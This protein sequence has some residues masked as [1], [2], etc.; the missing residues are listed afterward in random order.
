M[1][2]GKS[3]SES[4][5]ARQEVQGQCDIN[6]AVLAVRLLLADIKEGE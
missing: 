3:G 4:N 1:S 6:S 2:A 5:I